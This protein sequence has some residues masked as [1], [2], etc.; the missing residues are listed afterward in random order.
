MKKIIILFGPPGSG[1]GTQA[2]RIAESFGYRHISTGD[3]LRALSAAGTVDEQEQKALVAMQGG[4]LVPD[5]LIYKLA[6]QAITESLQAGQGVVLDGAIRNTAQAE[7]YQEFFK[8]RGVAAE[9]VA[10]E[11]A[12]PDELSLER[13]STR[14][15]CAAC[16]EIVPLT[17]PAAPAS[18]PKCGG[19]L[20][21]RAD[22]NQEVVRKRIELQGNQSLA[23]I[24]AFYQGQGTL[25]IINGNQSIAAVAEETSR[26]LNASEYVD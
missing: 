16:G 14:R 7:H 1:K 22:D 24:R 8:Q 11:I 2:K 21:A 20:V 15:V 9:V 23:P 18:C 19:K 10:I 17:G 6:F 13:L 4:A 3:L 26:I 25:K 5:W 12:L